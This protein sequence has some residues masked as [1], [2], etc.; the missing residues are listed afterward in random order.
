MAKYLDNTG[1][2]KLINW[3][4]QS[5]SEIG[6]SNSTLSL[7]TAET[8]L[9]I[10]KK[11]FQSVAYS[12]GKYVAVGD[13]GITGFSIDGINWTVIET[14]NG[15]PIKHIYA[16]EPKFGNAMFYVAC[17]MA[18]CDYSSSDDNMG[19]YPNWDMDFN[20][21]N[22]NA[23]LRGKSGVNL[24]FVGKLN[25]SRILS[26]NDG[27][28]LED[29]MEKFGAISGTSGYEWFAA[30]GSD[31]I[32]AVGY[33][34]SNAICISLI[35]PD[36]GL[37]YL[38]GTKYSLPAKANWTAVA[39]GTPSGASVYVAVAADSSV[40]A[41]STDKGETW[42]SMNLPSAEKWK[43]VAYGN[44]RFIAVSSESATAAYSSDGINWSSINI[45]YGESFNSIQ[46]VNDRFIALS[47]I[48]SV[49]VY[50]YDGIEWFQTEYTEM[51][52][53][54][55]CSAYGNNTMVVFVKNSD[56][57]L[58]S[59]DGF[60]W[61]QT[62]LPMAECWG[63]VVYGEPTSGSETRP[64][65][66][67][68]PYFYS[69]CYETNKILRSFDGI[70]WDIM[71]LPVTGDGVN[72]VAAYG[73]GKFV[74]LDGSNNMCLYSTNAADWTTKSVTL[75][76]INLVDM[77]Y[78]DSNGFY[79]IAANNSKF[80][81]GNKDATS[82][83]LYSYSNAK[84]SSIA[85]G[86]NS[87]LAV[88]E[89]QDFCYEIID[90]P[91]PT[92]ISMG[93]I[94]NFSSVAFGKTSDN[95]DVFVAVSNTANR[96]GYMT[97]SHLNMRFWDMPEGYGPHQEIIFAFDKFIAISANDNSYAYSDDV[98]NWSNRY[99]TII[100]GTGN[101]VTERVLKA[102]NINK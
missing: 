66:I 10:P 44:D 15:L 59:K 50:S 94:P 35:T 75:N 97:D 88:N 16:E 80:V 78:H 92:K 49:M 90:Y 53:R 89:D 67:A 31:R 100:D 93:E 62:K 86:K 99:E 95:T 52:N 73:N 27:I 56:V 76:G 102:L 37:P 51:T 30:N 21:S 20:W 63:K 26:S 7:A 60:H 3:I 79:G 28:Y 6:G 17:S 9:P 19:S 24:N 74:I 8:K 58:Y 12:N 57:A 29:E 61:K 36:F 68:L 48:N 42:L 1:L 85:A 69:R 25:T 98:M 34:T 38:G 43:S 14:A 18:N 70:N 45:P 64:V 91:F 46:F 13:D 23:T 84:W 55:I 4:K 83:S 87:V 54:E 77:C 101:D 11:L 2:A 40:G 72:F 33:N 81:I 82:W 96:I 65:F 39:E 47:N 32:V 22:G 41:Y 5:I 71:S